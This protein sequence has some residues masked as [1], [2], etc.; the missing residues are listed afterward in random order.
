VLKF[1]CAC[2]PVGLLL[3]VVCN[4]NNSWCFVARVHAHCRKVVE[5]INAEIPGELCLVRGRN[6]HLYTQLYNATEVIE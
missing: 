5:D 6:T 2:L 1:C 4:G 3:G